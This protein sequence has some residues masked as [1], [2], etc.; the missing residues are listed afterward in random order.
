MDERVVGE[1]RAAAT[2]EKPCATN[3][4]PN[5]V[6]VPSRERGTS[7]WWARD[8]PLQLTR[9]HVRRTS[10]RTEWRNT[11]THATEEALASSRKR[12]V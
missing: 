5:A 9:S 7:G 8:E 11:V 4:A 12:C 3:V 6:V 10:P 2:D 1:G